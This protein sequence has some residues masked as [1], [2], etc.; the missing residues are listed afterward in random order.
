MKRNAGFTL[1]EMLISMIVAGLILVA[2]VTL[3][4][5]QQEFYTTAADAAGAAGTLNRLDITLA[6]ELLPI[7]PAAGDLIYAGAD[8]MRLRLFRGVYSL[9]G[10]TTSP[11]ALTVK[12][13]TLGGEPAVGDTAF[14][15][16]QGPDASIKD[17][18]WDRF[19][20]IASDRGD[21][22]DGTPGWSLEYAGMTGTQ[23]AQLPPGAPIRPFGWASYWFESREHGYFLVRTDQDGNEV[24]LAG[25]FKQPG[26]AAEP[27]A[28]SYFDENGAVT[29]VPT[30]VARLDVS[31]TAVRFVT[32]SEDSPKTARRTL[33][34]RFRNR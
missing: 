7:N 34:F 20:I 14:V 11:P 15:Y 25:P 3:A 23:L 16:S 29:A 6:G 32:G 17:D 26:A 19:E 30:D 2:S 18:R 9:C 8:S 22:P 28:F 13:L 4:L 27:P 1:I 10:V 31:V 33:T 21:C 5:E 12:R 24:A